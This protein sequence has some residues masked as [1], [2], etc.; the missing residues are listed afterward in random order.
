MHTAY[1]GYL[2]T[3]TATGRNLMEKCQRPSITLEGLVVSYTARGEPALVVEKLHVEGP[4]LIQILGPNGAGKTTMLKAILG[5]VKPRSGRVVVCGRDVTSSPSEAGRHVGYVPQ[6]TA[7]SMGYPVTGWEIVEYEY[8]VRTAKPPRILSARKAVE[9]VRQAL[10]RVGLSE[11][12]WSKP[13]SELSGG[14]RQ[15]VMIARALV[16]NPPILLL[17][18]PFSAVD[19]KG[20]GEL[21]K[22]VGSL[23]REKLI[24]VTSH[25]PMLLLDYTDQ[26]VL[27]N[28][29]VVAYGPK[30]EV[31]RLD[32]LKKVYGE[33]AMPVVQHIHISDS[34]IHR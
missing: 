32:L 9:N 29:R 33:A 31:L 7:T 18:E 4:A 13:L 15:R 21:A 10:E 6:L 12:V 22:L 20:R 3:C 30:E 1:K 26:I 5:L 23:A 28:R 11:K 17:D 2:D 25:D 34:H 24:L 16:H 14:Q 19:P 27:V 8:L